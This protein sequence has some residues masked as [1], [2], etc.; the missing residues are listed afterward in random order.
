MAPRFATGPPTPPS[1]GDTGR[2]TF[3]ESEEHA[4]LRESVRGIG[5][6]YGAR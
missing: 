1:M 5:E 6:Q 4:L 2:V 3:V